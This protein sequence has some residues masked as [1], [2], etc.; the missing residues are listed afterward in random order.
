MKKVIALF[1]VVSIICL[2]G[3]SESEMKKALEDLRKKARVPNFQE[4]FTIRS[5]DLP[6]RPNL[7]LWD[8][9]DEWQL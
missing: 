9:S 5:W 1:L 7:E 8:S 6:T 3:N 2:H 4:F